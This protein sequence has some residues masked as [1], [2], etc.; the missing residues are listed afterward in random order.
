MAN[1][2]QFSLDLTAF[3]NATQAQLNVAVKKIVWDLYHKIDYISPVGDA[4][5]WKG[6]QRAD[7]TW[8]GVKPPEGYVGGRFRG[9]WQYA[10]GTIPSGDL[11][12]IDPSGSATR[13]RVRAG[14]NNGNPFTTHYIVNNLP[15]AVP[16]EEGH[17][18]H[19]APLGIVSVAIQSF[20]NILQQVGRE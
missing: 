4:E 13:A 2:S 5:W 7:G 18:W 9:N 14:I 15:Y 19:Q 6:T 8:T 3:A 12:N 10:K 16:L 11:P 17:S 1:I 20:P